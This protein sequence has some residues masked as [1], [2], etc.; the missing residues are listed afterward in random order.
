MVDKRTRTL[1]QAHARIDDVEKDV[2][3][4]KTTVQL[5][6]KELYSRIRRLEAILIAITGASLLLLLRMNF[7]G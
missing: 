4:M 1:N 3:E 6:V 2:I 5:T 7:L